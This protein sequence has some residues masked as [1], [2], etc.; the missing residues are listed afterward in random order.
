MQELE[1]LNATGG[2]QDA[3]VAWIAT[4]CKP[5]ERKDATNIK[6]FK[7]AVADHMSKCLMEV[8][9]ILTAVGINPQGVPNSK[10]ERVAVGPH[11]EWTREGTPGLQVR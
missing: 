8:G 6:E 9:P 3:L 2:S 10:R 5:V 11:P 4:S 7:K 1:A